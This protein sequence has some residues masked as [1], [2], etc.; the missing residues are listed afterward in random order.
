MI[1]N[2][3]VGRFQGKMVASECGVQ[4]HRGSDLD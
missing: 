2:Y 1:L 3:H 4:F